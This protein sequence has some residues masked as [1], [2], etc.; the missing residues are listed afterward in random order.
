MRPYP[1]PHPN[2][3]IG[4]HSKPACA[5]D[6]TGRGTFR[7]APYIFSFDPHLRDLSRSW[8]DARAGPLAF[9]SAISQQL[10]NT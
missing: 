5:R 9:K 1:P 4:R 7:Y 10:P 3:R 2:R 6:R 8:T